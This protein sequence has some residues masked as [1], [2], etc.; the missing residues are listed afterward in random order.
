MSDIPLSRREVLKY[1]IFGGAIAFATTKAIEFWGPALRDSL[2]PAIEPTF[3]VNIWSPEIIK[4]QDPKARHMELGGGAS[5]GMTTKEKEFALDHSQYIA[6]DCDYARVSPGAK[7][8][9]FFGNI[10]LAN[11]AESDDFPFFI[12]RGYRGYG[13]E[14]KPEVT[15]L[16]NH[17][18]NRIVSVSNPVFL[19]NQDIL[20]KVIESY[21]REKSSVQNRVEEGLTISYPSRAGFNHKG[22]NY[23]V[24]GLECLTDL[25]KR[26]F[27]IFWKTKMS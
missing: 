17:R 22:I 27:N 8:D 21:R 25:D 11:N 14:I 20:T 18:G 3:S 26:D 7:I 5:L 4:L 23:H 6:V 24:Y 9:L 12:E 2:F 15:F 19:S 10:Q 1:G 13:G 16:I